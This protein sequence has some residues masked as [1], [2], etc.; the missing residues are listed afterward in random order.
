MVGLPASV[1]L[2]P[3]DDPAAL[4]DL[5]GDAPVVAIGE[6]NHGV[7]EFGALRERLVRHLVRE[8]GFGVVALESGYAEGFL[9]DAWLRGGPGAV[10]DLA[11]D[12][13]TFRA[14]DAPEMQALVTGLREHRE[15]GGRVRF[16]G[17][18]IPGSGGS[19][20]PAL[21]LVREHLAAL[22][23][24]A[25]PLVDGALE[26]TRP[27]AA[28]NNGAAPA[29]YAALDA[30]ARDAATAALARLL[31]RV[32]ALG[33][34]HRVARHL[35]LGALRLDEQLREFAVL[36]A[37]DPPARVVSSRDVHMAETVRLLREETGERVVV[38][39]HNGH[40]QRVPFTFVPGVSAPSAGTALAEAYGD[41]YV[42]VG[43]T[44]L[45]GA[46]PGLALDDAERHG[47]ALHS[48]PLPDPEPGSVEQ[49][50]L[51]AGLGAEPVLLDLRA[52]RATPGPTSIRHA[53]THI[54][55]DV[56]AGYDA[57]YCLPHQE[58][59]AHIT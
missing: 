53:T 28:G 23:P 24:D 6:N 11:R 59:A 5:V 1:R 50:V 44:A 57:L 16:A 35:A 15:A 34:E 29:R 27:Y 42:V 26:A 36:F 48:D 55:V 45:A 38:L 25:V 21:R 54:P 41:G 49:A 39:A 19:P 33:P 40:V 30:P 32:E 14:G 52:A 51:D 37:P 3:A 13:F 56:L 10:E 31:L 17:L 12:G 4:A 9:V 18:D 58:P 47:I 46:T 2:L 22:A 7:G 20:E 43:L 8:L